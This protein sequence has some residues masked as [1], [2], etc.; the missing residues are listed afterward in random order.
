MLVFLFQSEQ[1]PLGSQS[2]A[3]ARIGELNPCYN[4]STEPINTANDDGGFNS[5]AARSNQPNMPHPP[6]GN[7]PDR[8]HLPKSN[9]PNRPRPLYTDPP[10]TLVRSEP[11]N[12]RP[13]CQYTEQNFVNE[14]FESDIEQGMGL[15]DEQLPTYRGNTKPALH[16][17][18][19]AVHRLSR[20]QPSVAGLGA[21]QALPVMKPMERASMRK[22]KRYSKRFRENPPGRMY[23]NPQSHPHGEPPVNRH[24]DPLARHDVPPGGRETVAPHSGR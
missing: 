14:C 21:L 16:N 20:T 1:Q 13:A 3:G 2:H 24:A 10:I 18:L 22:S 7:Q 11:R 12:A 17:D 6:H 19:E 15:K 8:P 23:E 9:T 5:L 4:Y